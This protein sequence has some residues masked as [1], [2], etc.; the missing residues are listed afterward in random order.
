M[1]CPFGA[2]RQLTPIPPVPTTRAWPG[3]GVAVGGACVGTSVRVGVWVGI[4]VRVGVAVAA[5][6]RVGVEVGMPVLVGV[7]VGA[8]V[9]GCVVIVRYWAAT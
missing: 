5:G 3:F 2:V 8:G 4:D 7:A 1:T 6:V 9:E